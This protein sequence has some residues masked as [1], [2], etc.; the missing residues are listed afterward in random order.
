[1]QESGS[2]RTVHTM[3][4]AAKVARSC[5][6]YIS[7]LCFVCRVVAF[8]EARP[9]PARVEA[10]ASRT[11]ECTQCVHAGYS[12]SSSGWRKLVAGL[13]LSATFTMQTM[14]IYFLDTIAGDG[15]SS[16]NFKA[17]LATDNSA[18]RLFRRGFI[19]AI[20]VAA[21]KNIVSLLASQSRFIGSR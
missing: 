6:L 16:S 2:P 12:F 18:M 11:T 7:N 1:M 3:Y 4:A 8:T 15:W 20:Q 21:S 13:L 19:Q 10:L 14:L 9:E 5:V 17:I